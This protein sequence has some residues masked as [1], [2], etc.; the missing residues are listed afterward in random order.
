MKC[1]CLV[2]DLVLS[3]IINGQINF[4]CSSC[5]IDGF[6]HQGQILYDKMDPIY[7]QWISV[8]DRLPELIEV[9]SGVFESDFVLCA[10]IPGSNHMAAPEIWIFYLYK[11]K[12]QKAE[13][14]YIGE[15][16]P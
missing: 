14:E 15:N 2:G 5:G 4:K 9:C 3:S 7:Y 1:K 11:S 13:W 10:N 12:N 6:I 8:E 16:N